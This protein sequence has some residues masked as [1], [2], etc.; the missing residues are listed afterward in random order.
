M[1]GVELCRSNA[2][3]ILALYVRAQAFCAAGRLSARKER[4]TNTV[5]F[6]LGPYSPATAQPFALLLRLRGETIVG[7]EPPGIG[8][9]RRGISALVEGRSIETALPIVAHSCS[10]AGTAHRIAFCRA[11]ESAAGAALSQA[12]TNTR[13]LFAEVERILARLWTLGATARAFGVAPLW[14]AALQQREDLFAALEDATGFRAFWGVAIPGGARDDLDF[15]PLRTA[16]DAVESSVTAWR[17]AVGPQGPLGRA[18]KGVGRLS[19]ESA[20]ELGI[21]GLAGAGSYATEDA[22]QA[23][24]GYTGLDVEWPSLDDKRSGD[25]A[26]RLACAVE[27]IAT[28]VALARAC[29]GALPAGNSDLAIAFSMPSRPVDLH[30]TVESPHGPVTLSATYAAAGTLGDLR[31]DTT[32]HAILDA[33]PTLLEGRPVAQALATLASLDL[34]LECLDQ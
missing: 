10:F 26:G 19:A 14:K 34:C 13:I 5:L 22:R 23:D 31:I 28:S 32:A 16:L 2:H 1:L 33:V 9:C 17:V 21:Y 11:L 29:L 25:V 4:S 18:G 6:P 3:A 27:D 20:R 30:A 7:V 12:A 8:Y 15:D 24:S